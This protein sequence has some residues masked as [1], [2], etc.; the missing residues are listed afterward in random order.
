MKDKNDKCENCLFYYNFGPDD[1]G[2]CRRFP[3]IVQRDANEGP[4]RAA[5][6]AWVTTNG[7]CGE[8][9]SKKTD[10]CR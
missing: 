7:W 2:L 3:P 10:S 9:M 5:M 4:N 8:Y 6:G 1:A